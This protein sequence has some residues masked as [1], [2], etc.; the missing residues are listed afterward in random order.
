L[1]SCM[2]LTEEDS[3]TRRSHINRIIKKNEKTFTQY[4]QQKGITNYLAEIYIINKQLF[5]IQANIDFKFKSIFDS[6][7][8]KY[9][10][11]LWPYFHD[12]ENRTTTHNK[13]GITIYLKASSE[14]PPHLLDIFQKNLETIG[15]SQTKVNLSYNNSDSYT[16]SPIFSV[17]TKN[18]IPNIVIDKPGCININEEKIT[19]LSPDPQ[20]GFCAAI[21][22]QF[23]HDTNTTILYL[24]VNAITQKNNNEEEFYNLISA[25]NKLSLLNVVLKN[26]N[27]AHALR[28]FYAEDGDSL[29]PI[30]DYEKLCKI[31]L[32]H[33]L[34]KWLK[35]A[36]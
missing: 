10:V 34:L 8:Q 32:L 14:V 2:E 20:E 31:D 30:A 9:D 17:F 24:I 21:I 19:K 7:L 4:T 5:A 36:F 27:V 13:K 11:D 6:I 1:I 18:N 25:T 15:I 22:N 3:A 16:N 35:P 23:K 28:K 26:D 12:I 29:F 33:R